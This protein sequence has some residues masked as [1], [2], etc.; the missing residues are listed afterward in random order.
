MFFSYDMKF[1]ARIRAI[2]FVRGEQRQI[3]IAKTAL[4]QHALHTSWQLSK[5]SALP[6][7][8]LTKSCDFRV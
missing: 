7:G 5:F 4:Q 3:L 6:Q 1:E 2:S 8:E